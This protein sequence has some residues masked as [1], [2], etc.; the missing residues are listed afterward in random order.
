[1]GVRRGEGGREGL[2]TFQSCDE[3][4]T[5]VDKTLSDGSNERSEEERERGAGGWRRVSKPVA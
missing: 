4:V 2:F 5:F 3:N 1:V